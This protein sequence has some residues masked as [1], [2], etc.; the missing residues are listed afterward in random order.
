MKKIIALVGMPGSGKSEAGIF[1]KQIGIPVLRFGSITDESIQK[2]GLPLTEEY[3]KPFREQLRRELGMA[4]FA[5]KMEP[6]IIAA[7]HDHTT[8]VLDGLRSWE[9]YTYLKQKFD[10][11]VLLAMY[12]SP[13]LR[14]KR[15]GERKERTLDPITA[16]ERDVKELNNLH[17]GPPIVFADYLIKNEKTY[18]KS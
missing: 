5:M 16:H 17:M 11:L 6:K 8:V 4:A 3:E 1:F 15:L 2:R 9:E 18:M 7:L 10:G 14:Y 12:A 13:S